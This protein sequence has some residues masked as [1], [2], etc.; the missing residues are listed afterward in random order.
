MQETVHNDPAVN[1]LLQSDDP[2]IRYLTLT[3]VL[4]KSE[5]SPEVESAGKQIPQGPKVQL[6]LSGQRTDGGFGVHPYQKWTGAHWRLV[7]NGHLSI[8]GM[9]VHRIRHLSSAQ[10]RR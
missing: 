7:S 10:R 1:W 9:D 6:L 3:E 2:S 4:G 8:S 5:D